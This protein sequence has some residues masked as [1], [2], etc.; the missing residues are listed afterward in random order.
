MSVPSTTGP[1]A[2]TAASAGETI[3]FSATGRRPGL[4]A[5]VKNALMLGYSV[6]AS[7]AS[8]G[9]APKMRLYA[10]YT[11][12]RRRRGTVRLASAPAALL[13]A[14]LGRTDSSRI[15]RRPSIAWRSECVHE[16]GMAAPSHGTCRAGAWKMATD[17]APDERPGWWSD[18]PQPIF[19]ASAA[20]PTTRPTM[21]ALKSCL[22]FHAEAEEA[23]NFYV[24]V[25][26]NSRVANVMRA[27][28]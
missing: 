16:R 15:R 13:M 7:S 19:A 26:P 2:P 6:S 3:A 17:P 18:A 5:R 11:A 20:L 22:W 28:G 25:F 8:S 1:A 14:C 24:S 9:D 10:R 27:N 4:S 12:G 23:A 21:P